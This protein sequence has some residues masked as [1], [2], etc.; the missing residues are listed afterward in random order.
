MVRTQV[1]NLSCVFTESGES[2][3][4]TTYCGYPIKMGKYGNGFTTSDICKFEIKEIQDILEKYDISEEDE[5]RILS[6]I[7][8][9]YFKVSQANRSARVMER[10]LNDAGVKVELLE[11]LKYSKEEKEKLPFDVEIDEDEHIDTDMD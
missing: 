7:K 10:M 11:Y 8:E 6:A 4:S 5:A 9:A 3:F 1:F 2:R